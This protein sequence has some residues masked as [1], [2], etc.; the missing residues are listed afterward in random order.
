V[1][2]LVC[3]GRDYTDSARVI[4]V[5]DRMHE[6][7]RITHLIHGDCRGADL[8]GDAWAISRGVQP[9]RCPALW[10]YHGSKTAGPIRNEA[11]AQLKPDVVVAFPGGAGTADMLRAAQKLR[12]KIIAV[13]K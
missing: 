7:E 12:I 9:V 6:K 3:G 2:V 5:L 1:K 10:K 11:M 13:P 8:L 4:H